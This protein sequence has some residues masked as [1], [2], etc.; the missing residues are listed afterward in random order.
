M[1]GGKFA[2]WQGTIAARGPLAAKGLRPRRGLELV[3]LPRRGRAAMRLV[4]LP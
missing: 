4:A 3:G 2:A 1:T